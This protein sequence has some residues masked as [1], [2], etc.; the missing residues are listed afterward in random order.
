MFVPLL[1]SLYTSPLGD[2]ARKHGIPFHLS[3]DDTQLYLSFTSN[4][5]NHASN[6]KETVELCVKDIG[7][8]MLCN[9]L[10][11]NKIRRNF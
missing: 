11:L 7:D 5:P 2:I 6:A 9:K 10:P 1:Y 4:G 3:A 8:R